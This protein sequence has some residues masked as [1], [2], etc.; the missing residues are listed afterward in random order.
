MFTEVKVV[1]VNGQDTLNIQTVKGDTIGSPNAVGLTLQATDSN[2]APYDLTG[3]RIRI[4]VKKTKTVVAAAMTFDSDSTDVTPGGAGEIDMADA[5][6]GNFT[7]KKNAAQ[8]DALQPFSDYP[9]DIEFLYPTG[10]V[11]TWVSG[12]WTHVQ[13]ITTNL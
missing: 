8:M 7:L 9:Y 10:D 3:V 1:Q 12:E 6:N 5:I 11:W 2:N 4:M 13:D